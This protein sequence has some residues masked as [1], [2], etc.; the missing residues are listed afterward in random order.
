MS[1]NII[2]GTVRGKNADGSYVV[3][4]RNGSPLN[5]FF[6]GTSPM[7]G[8]DIMGN[9][10]ADENGRVSL[11]LQPTVLDA[12]LAGHA[13]IIPVSKR[14]DLT[15][16]VL[17]KILERH[18]SAVIKPG[19]G[20]S[21]ERK[22]HSDDP[23]LFFAMEAFRP[24]AERLGIALNVIDV[25]AVTRSPWD[26]RQLQDFSLP[27]DVEGSR[28]SKDE[29]TKVLRSGFHPTCSRLVEH[30]TGT[31][32]ISINFVLPYSPFAGSIGFARD[33]AGMDIGVFP[34]CSMDI[35]ETR[36]LSS[37]RQMA[38]AIA[39]SRLSAG[40]GFQA[41]I[42][43]SPVT[44][45]RSNCFAD[46]AAALVFLSRGGRAGVV[47]EYALL[48]EASLYFGFDTNT[49]EL[50]AGVLENAT[51][52]ALRAALNTPVEPD[53]DIRSLVT[54]AVRIA[55]T[56]ALPG[57][58]FTDSGAVS[59]QEMHG[60]VASANLIANDI[61][62]A[63]MAEV[64]ALSVKYRN[65]LEQLVAEHGDNGVSAYRLMTF[66]SVNVPDRMEHVFRSMIAPLGPVVDAH[67]NELNDRQSAAQS[68]R[69][70]TDA[71]YAGFADRI[72][73]S[74]GSSEIMDFEF[75]D[76]PVPGMSV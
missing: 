7:V 40:K 57:I 76:A 24:E 36:R 19:A 1:D 11:A 33:V 8:A 72:A 29:L 38:L 65:D 23:D 17:A 34:M 26:M 45:H 61:R 56:T 68:R 12:I 32:G 53:E 73:A 30:F 4:R 59:E 71:V 46:A 9:T 20:M 64:D 31:S 5:V 70:K 14:A 54:K 22:P 27:A 2:V 43:S 3:V 10:A 13:R 67:A 50:R 60:A 39:H 41:D 48:R 6:K 69:A 15:V 18:K 16:R 63:P 37:A 74:V 25:K 62:Q 58:R 47:D 42:D 21:I 51:H 44:R 75:S 35:S 52:R 28:R 66:G 49:R 55:K